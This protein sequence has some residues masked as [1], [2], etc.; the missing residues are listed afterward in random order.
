MRERYVPVQLC[1][2]QS[3][4]SS[5][6]A[7]A[8]MLACNSVAAQADLSGK[9]LAEAHCSRCHL[10]PEPSDLPKET[11]PL[12]LGW[13]GNYLGIHDDDKRIQ[14]LIKEEYVLSGPI[15]SAE[16]FELLKRY[17]V[18]NAPTQSEALVKKEEPS[19]LTGFRVLVPPLDIPDTGMIFSLAVDETRGLL[20][21]G[22]AGTEQTI[23]AFDIA[24]YKRIAKETLES[25]P[26]QI[27]LTE[28]GVEVG[29]MGGWLRSTGNG[30]VL[31]IENIG[32]EQQ[33]TRMLINGFNRLTSFTKHDLNGDNL[34][35]MVLT[36]FGSRNDPVTH[37]EV[38]IYWQTPALEKLWESAPTQVPP[39]P[40]PGG[41]RKTALVVDTPGNLGTIVDDFNND[42][43]PDILSLEADQLQQIVLFANK[44]NERFE[45]QVLMQ[46]P[47]IWGNQMFSATDFNGDSLTDLL[48][49]NGDQ[50]F[51]TEK[52]SLPY[53]GVRIFENNGDL[54]FTEK[55]FYPVYGATRFIAKD[56]DGDGDLDIV[57]I[58]MFPRLH[59]ERMTETFVYLENQGNYEFTASTLPEE[60]FGRW[61]SI[62]IG[63][64]NK[65]KKPD[66]VLGRIRD[67]FAGEPAEINKLFTDEMLS[68][69]NYKGKVG[70][71]KIL[72]LINEQN[73]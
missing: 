38:S 66:I 59:G 62:A 36:G 30:Q 51:A 73:D 37:G 10:V 28:T 48:V 2:L 7:L 18:D 43:R 63:D 13:M 12:V 46:W 25:A 50:N 34:K 57:G 54:T 1:L 15:I 32:T 8:S 4:L 16:D 52:P 5:V 26:I 68:D 39:G 58:A 20:Y 19:P 35:D 31:N 42:G 67:F 72:Y 11:W 65:D 49:T 60:Y 21:V 40:L 71:Y 23:L 47:V 6:I 27:D 69:Y 14:F 61:M 44:G 17:Y 22:T 55:F 64:I 3:F 41:F 45:R 56:L 29:T 33:R 24:S 9:Q 53:H 70:K